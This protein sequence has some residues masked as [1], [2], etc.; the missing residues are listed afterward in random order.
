MRAVT[1][2]AA[3]EPRPEEGLHPRLLPPGLRGRASVVRLERYWYVVA[4]SEELGKAPL[5]RTLL[6]AP[7]VL[8]R[9]ADGR[10]A[11]LLDRCPHRN[12]PLSLG[13]VRDGQL[14]C[15]Y[16]GWRFDGAGTCKHV[17]SLVGEADVK[18]RAATRFATREADGFVWAWGK[19]GDE[20]DKE[21]YRFRL[22]N[23]P[24]YTTLRQHVRAE[25]TLHA[26]LENALDVPHTQFLHKG[27]FRSASRGITI[28]ARV[29]RT[30]DRV[31]AEYVGEPRP[32][33][34]VARLLSPSG[35]LVTHTDRFVLPSVAEVEYAIGTENHLL[36]AT[37]MTPVSDFE[38]SLYAAVSFR[39]RVPGRVVKP[40]V[41]PFA[42]AIFKQDADLLKTQTDTIR[43]FGGEQYAWTD[44]DVLGKHIWRMLRAAERGDAAT[45]PG[46][47][48]EETVSLI[49]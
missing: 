35:G 29:R 10:A 40:L 43:R 47:T 12:V 30:H 44:I 39:V 33:G 3:R 17:P 11:A 26:A 15:A 21:P 16:H 24:G 1:D 14:E 8:F 36:I 38:T 22:A 42:L 41:K 46:E 19:P 7:L 32:T 6:G 45:P 20:P 27:L 25:C 37:A 5:A 31:E 49:V 28:E 34:L 48:H 13:R 9:E 23:E 18:G 2:E 4:T